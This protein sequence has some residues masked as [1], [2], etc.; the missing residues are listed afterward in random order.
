MVKHAARSVLLLFVA[1]VF[2]LAGCSSPETGT[3]GPS[4]DVPT[5]ATGAPSSSASAPTSSA[6]GTAA[7]ASIDPCSLLSKSDLTEYGTFT[8]PESKEQGGARA[9]IFTR[10]LA[11]ASDKSLTVSINVRDSQGT[12]T[13]NDAG[14]GK[15]SGKVNGRPSVETASTVDRGCLV[16]LSV[17]DAS[18]VDVS[19]TS[20]SAQA[21][22]A[23][24]EPLANVV[25]PK[26]PKS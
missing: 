3:P 25:E 4:P 8:G 5:G 1:G 12:S 15:T 13:V 14:A 9:C 7:T 6:G 2:S 21:A 11:S 19:V 22:C 16:A 18:R 23:V 24:A 26:L 17:G 20:D 10:Q